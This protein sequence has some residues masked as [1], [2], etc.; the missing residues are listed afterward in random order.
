M[1][2]CG[3]PA[4]EDRAAAE[5][6]A[7]EEARA[8]AEPTLVAEESAVAS[9]PSG[10]SEETTVAETQVESAFGVEMGTEAAPVTEA[11]AGS[12]PFS[13][14]VESIPLSESVAARSPRAAQEE[15]RALTE[16]LQVFG[17]TPALDEATLA[18]EELRAAAESRAVEA[19]PHAEPQVAEPL[20]VV[21]VEHVEAEAHA[22]EPQLFQTA[23]GEAQAAEES[24]VQHVEETELRHVG[25]S[26]TQPLVES[27]QVAPQVAAETSEQ[28]PPVGAETTAEVAAPFAETGQA[29][30]FEEG[31][32]AVEATREIEHAPVGVAGETAASKEEVAAKE[33]TAAGEWFEFDIQEARFESQP[34]A[35]EPAAS[36]S[37]ASSGEA[38]SPAADEVGRAAVEAQTFE[39]AST[40]IEHSPEPAHVENGRPAPAAEAQ[41]KGVAP[42]DEV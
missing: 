14:S 41:E 32:G 20:Y 27:E 35:V 10:V 19:P 13:E 38:V 42:F 18:S 30:L 24:E 11:T 22:A 5:T 23:V 39:G 16:E 29:T 12:A 40:Q 26:A 34:T 7:A 6:R 25:E 4:K 9:E 21:G 2:F 3:E 36:V 31:A 28:P 1:E 33:E 17:E 37:E 15:L 8:A